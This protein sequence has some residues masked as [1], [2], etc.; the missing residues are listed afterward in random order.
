M[1]RSQQGAG[2]AYYAAVSLHNAAIAESVSGDQREAIRIGEQALEAFDRLAYPASERFSTHGVLATCW[3]DLGD[4]LRS[5][6]HVHLGLDSGGEHADAPAG[7]AFLYARLG[8]VD[9]ARRMLARAAAVERQGLSDLEASDV[10]ALARASLFVTVDPGRSLEVMA[11][12]P[13]ERPLDVGNT[14]D[15]DMTV[16]LSSLLA[17]DTEAASR[18]SLRGL[19]DARNQMAR[20]AEVRFALLHALATSDGS[21]AASAIEEA[22]TVGQLTLLEVADAIGQSLHQLTPIPGS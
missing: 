18:I 22:A 17:G 6:E 21:A 10:M 1:A 11:E 8:D 14:F 5:D 4:M 7:L 19:Q 9:R 15:H 16:A 13:R 20:S 3:A 12:R 2:H